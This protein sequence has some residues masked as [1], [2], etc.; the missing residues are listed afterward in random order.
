MR[1]TSGLIQ[2]DPHCCQI[3]IRLRRGDTTLDL[4]GINNQPFARMDRFSAVQ[5]VPADQAFGHV[6]LP[7]QN[8][9]DFIIFPLPENGPEFQDLDP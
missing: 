2:D 4:L 3:S 7:C 9:E 8:T 5:A 1:F 6:A